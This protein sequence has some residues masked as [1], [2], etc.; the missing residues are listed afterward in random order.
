MVEIIGEDRSAARAA[1]KIYGVSLRP[2]VVVTGRKN[3]ITELLEPKVKG[4]LSISQPNGAFAQPGQQK[5]RRPNCI[6]S[7]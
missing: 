1:A 4:I 7:K 2:G 6:I 3:R 5:K